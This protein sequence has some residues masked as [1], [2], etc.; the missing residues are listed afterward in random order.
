MRFFYKAT[1]CEDYMTWEEFKK[2]KIFVVPC[3]TKE[4]VENLPAGLYEFYA[5]PENNPLSTPTGKLEYYATQIAEFTPDDPER[6]PVPHWI[7]RS[8]N[9]DERLSSPRA[10][11]YPLLCMSNHGR[12]RMHAQCDDIIWTREIE[13]MKVRGKDGY[14]YEPVWLNPK[15]A[16]K[17]GIRHGDIVKVFN[18]RGIVLCG[19]YV[20]E[21]LVEQTC[22]VDHGS[23]LDPIIPG[24]LD[25]G[26]AINCITPTATTSKNATGMA[27]S[28][29][30]VEVEKVTDAEWES[31]KRDYPEAF[32]RKLDP[33]A[34]VCLAGWLLTEDEMEAQ[35]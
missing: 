18:E 11:K 29:F 6:M 27:V 10:E 15:E 28:G 4:E 17:R 1:G 22:Y 9:H 33:D 13:T 14:L 8:E 34:G 30:L 19:A 31:W 2:Q 26:G 23:R 35:A 3:K 24:Y 5:D 12:W 7:E 16:E 21:R 20:T 32:A 25:R